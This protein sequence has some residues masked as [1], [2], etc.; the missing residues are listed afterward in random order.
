MQNSFTPYAK[1]QL[2]SG[3]KYPVLYLKIAEGLEFPKEITWWFDDAITEGGQLSWS[4]RNTK[5]EWANL[6][7]KD[8]I[9]FAQLNDWKAYFDGSDM[10]GNPKV[11]VVDLGN[12]SVTFEV[13]SFNVWLEKALRD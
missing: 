4:L 10:S 9:P 5:K 13:A 1:E 7:K 8:L 6:A 12:K 3:F 11:I 2:P